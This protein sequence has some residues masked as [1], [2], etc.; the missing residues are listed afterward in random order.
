M[1]RRTLTGQ[2]AVDFLKNNPNADFNV[3]SGDT[4]LIPENVGKAWGSDNLLTN[5]FR[6]VVVDPFA[7]LSQGTAGLTA[8]ALGAITGD[9]VSTTDMSSGILGRDVYQEAVDN[10]LL[11]FGKGAAG[12][13]SLGVGGGGAAATA[14]GRIAQAA[15]LGAA[16]GALGGLGASRTGQEFSDTLSGAA[17]GGI[18]GGVAGLGGE[19]I[20]RLS[21]GTPVDRF[22]REFGDITDEEAAMI[23]MTSKRAGDQGQ[24]LAE[25]IAGRMDTM[26]P[27]Q[28]SKALSLLDVAEKAGAPEDTLNITRKF[29]KETAGVDEGADAVSTLF[30]TA[31]DVAVPAAKNV[32]GKAAINQAKGSG[33]YDDA[34]SNADNVKN[35][36]E[37]RNSLRAVGEDVGLTPAAT[38]ESSSRALNK[39]GAAK[40]NAL[41][42]VAIGADD[43]VNTL[44]NFDSKLRGVGV[45]GADDIADDLTGSYGKVRNIMKNRLENVRG[46]LDP[47][48]LDNIATEFQGLAF[49]ETGAKKTD[50][51][52]AYRKAAESIRDLLKGKSSEYAKVQSNFSTILENTKSRAPLTKSVKGQRAGI[53]VGGRLGSAGLEVPGSEAIKG[54]GSALRSTIGRVQERGIGLPSIGR[55]DNVAVANRAAALSPQASRVGMLAGVAAAQPSAGAQ[56]PDMVSQLAGGDIGSSLITGA[57][58][59]EQQYA[60]LVLDLIANGA[61]PDEA[62]FLAQIILQ[63]NGVSMTG[64][65]EGGTQPTTDLGRKAYLARDAATQ[66]LATLQANPDVSGK[67]QSIENAFKEL[68]GTADAATAYKT[69]L[70][71]MRTLVMT[72]LGGA[73]LPPGEIE[74]FEKFLPKI[75]DSPQR[76]EQKLQQLIPQLESLI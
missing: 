38:L 51:A 50:V 54:T 64:G 73:T 49:T 36:N 9:N 37:V 28:A 55:F 48:E 39:L 34:I 2:A 20:R 10:P 56:S 76:A 26:N 52:D 69:Q 13:A 41:D 31:D 62:E 40:A 19:A 47:V 68:F 30:G 42:N 46:T 3:L 21:G 72:A 43:L 17:F 11:A 58:S 44:D 7:K 60:A 23:A 66:A 18:A 1:A 70:E 67:T 45:L 29:L 27:Q 4:S 74:R 57:A 32:T 14:G 61:S 75:T 71:T 65:A 6:S 12:I 22:V 15:K 63:A 35:F 8:K 59:P 25:L 24:D 16:G 5:I 33:L 53:E